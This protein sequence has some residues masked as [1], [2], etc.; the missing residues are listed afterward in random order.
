M[1]YVS[2][3][4]RFKEEL[5]HELVKNTRT[6]KCLNQ[7]YMKKIATLE[8][9]AISLK[10]QLTKVQCICNVTI[11]TLP[12]YLFSNIIY[13]TNPFIHI[14]ICTCIPLSIFIIILMNLSD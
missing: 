2:L 8:K 11:I 9:E 6:V 5:I 4:V 7:A 1:L 10:E 14:P 3:T 12:I 13:I